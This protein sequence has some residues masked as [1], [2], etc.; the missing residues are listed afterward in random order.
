MV[1]SRDGE[2]E[3]RRKKEEERRKR[4]EG[5]RKKEGGKKE[6]RK[7]ERGKRK[8]GKKER[9]KE[10]KEQFPHRNA[11]RAKCY[12]ERFYFGGQALSR[13]VTLW[14]AL[15]RELALDKKI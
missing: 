1:A 13:L 2:E 10:G 5:G 4:E 9:R 7:E 12:G 14:G 3:G 6:R 15:L 11:G 8:E